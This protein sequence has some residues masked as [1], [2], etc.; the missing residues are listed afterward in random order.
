MTTYIKIFAGLCNRLFQYSYG[1][2]L[3]NQGE[4]IKFIVADD[5]NT[6]ILE[7]MN[8]DSEKDLFITRRNTGYWKYNGIKLLSKYITHKYRVGFYQEKRFADCADFSFLREKSY[9]ENELYKKISSGNSVSIHIRGGDYL[10]E[11]KAGKFIGVCNT[12]YY[13]RAIKKIMTE[14]K[15]P[16]F[17]IFTNDKG[18]AMQIVSQCHLGELGI[19]VMFAENEED[20]GQD[21]YLMSQCRHNILANS[22]FSWWAAYL[23]HN[24]GKTVIV[25]Q[26]WTNDGDAERDK[27]ILDGWCRL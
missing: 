20:A 17:F 13:I 21:L 7:V 2:Y 1:K 11:S 12:A 3:L 27:I 18:Y 19:P 9:R 4:K 15:N 22:T 25:P 6:D 23:N 16:E 5:G 14:Q 24:D 26:H 10:D 8:L